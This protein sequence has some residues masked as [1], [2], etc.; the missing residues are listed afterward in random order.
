[1]EAAVSLTSSN[2]VVVLELLLTFTIW[3]F[4]PP[5]LRV[6]LVSLHAEPP[7]SRLEPHVV[8]QLE[9]KVWERSLWCCTDWQKPSSKSSRTEPEGEGR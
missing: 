7:W 3:I 8:L 9:L 6:F 1:M 4:R 5:P 2:G